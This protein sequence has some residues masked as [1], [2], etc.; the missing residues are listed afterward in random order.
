MV[1]R[2]VAGGLTVLE[3]GWAL[4]LSWSWGS[5]V[6]CV[7][8]GSSGCNGPAMAPVLSQG[9]LTL[10]VLL[11][12]DGAIGVWGAKFAF[13]VGVA[14]S[15]ALLLAATY[16]ALNWGADVLA[17]I[18]SWVGAGLATVGIA[19]NAAAA[20]TKGQLSEQAN[21]MNLPVFG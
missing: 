17:G 13:Y 21:P 3:G 2:R 16:G 10:A 1:G 14:L 9:A 6:I 5:T 11:L 4:L 20:R 7:P 15:A 18:P 19:A 12:L 8:S